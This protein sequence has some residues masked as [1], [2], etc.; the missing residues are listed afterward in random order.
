MT[1]RIGFPTRRLDN[2]EERWAWI[3][4]STNGMLQLWDGTST[5][6]PNLSP[7]TCASLNQMRMRDAA[8]PYLQSN[9]GLPV[10]HE[11]FTLPKV[12]L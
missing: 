10:N 9:R 4:N 3:D 2:L 11:K 1:F 8:T 5:A 7:G 6:G 12:A